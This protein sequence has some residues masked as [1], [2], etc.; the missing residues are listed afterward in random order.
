MPCRRSRL[1]VLVAFGF[2]VPD[3]RHV[4]AHLAVVAPGEAPEGVTGGVTWSQGRGAPVG[5]GY[6]MHV[7]GKMLEDGKML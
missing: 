5:Y 1:D 3:V 4:G 6:G 2:Q 7:M